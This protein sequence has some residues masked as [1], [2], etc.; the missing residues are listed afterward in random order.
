MVD[1]IHDLYVIRI[2]LNGLSE[3]IKRQWPQLG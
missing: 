3:P 1:T 2:N